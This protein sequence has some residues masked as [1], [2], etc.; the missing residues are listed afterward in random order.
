MTTL[1]HQ[2]FVTERL[3]TSGFLSSLLRVFASVERW[4]G[5]RQ[6]LALLSRLD[7]HLLM[8]VGLEP[9]F[10]PSDVYGALDGQHA[11]PWGKPHSRPDIR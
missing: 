5:R 9:G 1:E 10:E 4:H 7:E 2:E 3:G 11:S 8:D 6:T